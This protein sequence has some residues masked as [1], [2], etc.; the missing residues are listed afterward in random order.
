VVLPALVPELSY[1]GLEI[2]DGDTAMVA[3]ALMAKG[4]MGQEEMEQKRTELLEYCMLDTLAM[5]RLH[6]KLFELMNNNS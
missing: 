5:V 4:M 2:A 1:E 3:F 6:E